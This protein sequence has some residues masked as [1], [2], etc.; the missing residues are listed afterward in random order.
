MTLKIYINN[1]PIE[2]YAPSELAEIKLKLTDT[3]MSAAGYIRKN[4][5]EKEIQNWLY[6]AAY[7]GGTRQP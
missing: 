7:R 3:A 1:R 6:S 5:E 4:H 2:D